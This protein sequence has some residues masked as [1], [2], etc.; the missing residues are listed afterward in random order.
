MFTLKRPV[1]I[2][3]AITKLQMG[4]LL[5][6]TAKTAFDGLGYEAPPGC[7]KPTAQSLEKA[8]QLLRANHSN[9]QVKFNDRKFHNHLAHIL[10]AAYYLGASPQ[11][12]TAIYEEDIKDLVEWKE[13]SPEELDMTTY[14]KHLGDVRYE[15][16]F[17][18]LFQE[19]VTDVASYDW[20]AVANEV[21]SH[22]EGVPNSGALFPGLAFGLLHPLIH[23]SYAFEL[24]AAPVAVEAM[25]LACMDFRKSARKLMEKRDPPAVQY[26][27]PMEVLKLLQQDKSLDGVEFDLVMDPVNK[28]L[29]TVIKYADM[30][31]L[32]DDPLKL[33][34]TLVH[35]SVAYFG[36]SHKD[37]KPRYSFFFLHGLT[38]SQ[39]LCEIVASKHF[40]EVFKDPNA[41]QTL[42]YFVWVNFIVLYM[43]HL[44]PTIDPKRIIDADTP[45]LADAYPKAVELALG[46]EDRFDEHYVKAIRALMFA[47]KFVHEHR[48]DLADSVPKD[49]YAKAA[50]LFAKNKPGKKF[51][52]NNGDSDLELDW[53][54]AE[55]NT[56]REK[57]AIKQDD[58]FE[59]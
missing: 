49:Y 22:T 53:T 23:L 39:A 37:D 58:L 29:D 41:A 30:L 57:D 4:N 1:H 21:Y 45:V 38:G 59:G 17:F 5:S 18:D 52:Y 35:D 34:A 16:G 43:Y 9:Y 11:Q 42:G 40:P 44:R 47:D 28:Q 50:W 15:R 55:I 54:W 14:V 12:L 10:G 6:T 33:A 20:K 32:P 3:S 7:P 13:D 8:H 19:E 51:V 27:N 25:T 48:P 36:A 31:A 56:Q 46:S 26:S 24:D 2:S